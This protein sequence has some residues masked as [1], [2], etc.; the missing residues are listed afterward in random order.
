MLQLEWKDVDLNISYLTSWHCLRHQ[1]V[2]QH[3][4][5]IVGEVSK[6]SP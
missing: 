3:N 1:L 5:C 2:S 4:E 6:E